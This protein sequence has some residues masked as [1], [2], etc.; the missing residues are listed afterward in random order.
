MR[1]GEDGSHTLKRYC[2]ERSGLEV[3]LPGSFA[4]WIVE[5]CASLSPARC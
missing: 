1:S 5:K 2:L 4:Q 3:A